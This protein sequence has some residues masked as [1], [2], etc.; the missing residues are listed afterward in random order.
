MGEESVE[1]GDAGGLPP[2][3]DPLEDTLRFGSSLLPLLL[4]AWVLT[5][6]SAP[7]GRRCKL[8]ECT[9]LL[10]KCFVT[11]KDKDQGVT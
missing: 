3:W 4:A 11:T 10:N 5:E 6:P 8:A 9:L 7:G 1:L 2:F